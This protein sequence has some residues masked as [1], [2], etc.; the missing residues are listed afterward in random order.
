MTIVIPA[1]SLGTTP[2]VLPNA[3]SMSPVAD[4]KNKKLPG[5]MSRRRKVAGARCLAMPK[6]QFLLS[7]MI[8]ISFVST[9]AGDGIFENS[10]SP[11]FTINVLPG[12]TE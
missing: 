11:P 12:Y 6:P 8:C 5:R 7:I 10:S 4:S 2:F 1:S 3:T 9:H